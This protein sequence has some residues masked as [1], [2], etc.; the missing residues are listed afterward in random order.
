MQD[1]LGL[2]T[3]SLNLV[4]GSDYA[5]AWFGISARILL[6]RALDLATGRHTFKSEGNQ[7]QPDRFTGGSGTAVLVVL[8]SVVFDL[9]LAVNVGPAFVHELPSQTSGAQ[10]KDQPPGVGHQQDDLGHHTRTGHDLPPA[11]NGTDH[12]RGVGDGQDG[13]ED[14]HALGLLL[15]PVENV[16]LGSGDPERVLRFFSG[17]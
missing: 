10:Q 14:R 17:M 9:D 6:K 1:V 8:F 16:L 11:Q 5:R 3:Q 7:S 13:E 2:N 15:V 12:H 4:H